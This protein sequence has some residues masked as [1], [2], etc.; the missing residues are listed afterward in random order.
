[1]A[2]RRRLPVLQ[3]KAPPGSGGAGG[4]DDDE[5]PRAPWQWV[6]FGTVAIFAAWLPLSYL[7]NVLVRR[8]L[9][10]EFGASASAAEIAERLQAMPSSAR[11]RVVAIE[12]TPHLLA[13]A[14]AAFAGG[15]LVGRYGPNAG[16][17]EGAACGIGIA[18]LAVVI[19]C[20]EAG[21][22]LGPLLALI[23]A[24]IFAAWGSASGGARARRAGQTIP[25]FPEK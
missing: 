22:S 5:V 24:A 17:R 4:S 1:M 7:A 16:A 12:M 14:I 20:I 19:S 10:S 23:P 2:E 6:G 18:L 9:A 25:K 21:P 3:N 8:A 15:W 11:T 13:L